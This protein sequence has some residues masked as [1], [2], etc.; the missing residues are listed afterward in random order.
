MNFILTQ[1]SKAKTLFTILLLLFSSFV[2]CEATNGSSSNDY[3]ENIDSKSSHEPISG[4]GQNKVSWGLEYGTAPTYGFY[5]ATASKSKTGFYF[6]IKSSFRSPDEKDVY[7]FSK[8]YATSTLG[9]SQTGTKTN[10]VSINGGVVYG[11]HDNISLIGALGIVNKTEYLSFYDNTGIL[12]SGNTYYIKGEDKNSINAI[13][14]AMFYIEKINLK[15]Q[16]ESGVSSVA[17][18]VGGFFN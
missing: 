15:I 16:Y 2:Y 17:F 4:D 7:K 5:V 10:Y 13:L 14:G 6:D 11:I 9:D 1:P 12:G 18:G 8:T 3:S